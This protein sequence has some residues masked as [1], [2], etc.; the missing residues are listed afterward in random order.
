MSFESLESLSANRWQQLKENAHHISP[1]HA[2][3]LRVS[4]VEI[5]A[6]ADNFEI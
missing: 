1:L 5:F 3:L 2:T 6:P 4:Y